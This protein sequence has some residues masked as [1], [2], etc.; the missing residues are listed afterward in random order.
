LGV[1]TDKNEF[2]PF[3]MIKPKIEATYH[4]RLVQFFSVMVF[5]FT[6]VFIRYT[7]AD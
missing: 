7:I 1:T 3:S 6:L 2:L 4:Y 5:Q